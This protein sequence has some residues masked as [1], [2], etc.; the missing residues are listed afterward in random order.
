MATIKF[1][2]LQINI[3]TINV[4]VLNVIGEVI[5]SVRFEIINRTKDVYL[6]KMT[7]R[8]KILIKS[9]TV[10]SHTAEGDSGDT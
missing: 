10:S 9:D 2:H 3:A 7:S 1:L 5:C 6:Q 4:V 8:S